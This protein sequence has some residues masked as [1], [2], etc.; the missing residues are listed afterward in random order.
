MS[1]LLPPGTYTVKLSAAGSELS[2]PLIVRKDPNSG[3]TEADIVNQTAM[4]Q[5]LWKDLDEASRMVNQIELIRSQLLKLDTTATAVK[6]AAGTLNQKLIEIEDSLVQRK[7][8]GQGQDGVRWPPKLLSKINYLAGGL[9]S[10]DYGPT[11]QQGEVQFLLKRQLAE[12][13]QRLNRVL[14]EDLTAF[15]K[16]LVD[17]NVGTAIKRTP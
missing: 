14:N 5:E 17:N 10:S 1:I 8:T 2:Q 6:S 4:L 11:K 13:R 3:G 7:L 15:D 9:A 12:V 16:L